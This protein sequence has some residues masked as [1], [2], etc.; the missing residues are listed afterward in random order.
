MAHAKESHWGVVQN[1]NDGQDLAGISHAN[2]LPLTVLDCRD[3]QE[4]GSPCTAKSNAS[5]TAARDLMKHGPWAE[6]NDNTFA[7]AYTPRSPL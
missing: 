3:S 7:D 4:A 6:G 2:S 5:Q 1:A